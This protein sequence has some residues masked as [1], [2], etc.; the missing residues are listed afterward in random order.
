MQSALISAVLLVG[1]STYAAAH[2]HV[3]VDTTLRIVVDDGGQATGV[4]IGW[5]YD[6]FYSL[7]LLED[8]RL[9]PDGDGAL[10]DQELKVLNG[11]DLNW[12]DDFEG[13]TYVLS[14]GAPV[15]LSR[16]E[17]RGVRVEN[18]LITTT[19]FRAFTAP[20]QGLEIKAYDPGFYTAYSIVGAE[21]LV[22][23]CSGAIVPADLE[24][25]YTLLEELLYALPSSEAEA[26]Y[27]EVGEA[28]SDTVALTCDGS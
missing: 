5:T 15:G 24:A 21:D 26:N 12:A 10:T 17:K 11:F 27:P 28:F 7:L 9:D 18:G 14:N 22:G 23:A 4:E 2:P 25:A 20:L 8:M 1:S 3:F 6:A 13:D 16:P 19:H